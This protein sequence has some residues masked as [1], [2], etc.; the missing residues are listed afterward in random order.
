MQIERSNVSDLVVNSL[1]DGSRIIVNSQNETVFALNATAGAAWDACSKPITLAQLTERMQRCFDPN[2]TEELAG[3][4]IQK[5]AEKNLV[6]L[7]GTPPKATRR[8]VLAGLGAVALPLVVSLTATEQRAYARDARSA[9][10]FDDKRIHDGKP[11]ASD[12]HH[13]EHRDHH[14]EDDHD[15]NH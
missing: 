7:A 12:P 8:E 3:A 10:S 4:A 6:L 2:V 13:H 14:D 1:P 5:L 15:R 11:H 9:T